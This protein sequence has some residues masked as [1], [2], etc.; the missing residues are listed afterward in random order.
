MAERETSA[1]IDEQAAEWALRVDDASFRPADKAAMDA[2]LGGDARRIGAYAKARAVLI[3]AR[4]ASALGSGFDPDAYLAANGHAGAQ[5]ADAEDRVLSRA[6]PRRAALLGGVGL[7]GFGTIAALGFSLQAAARTYS[8]RRG[9]I[10]LVPLNDGSTITLNTASMVKVR[11]NRRERHVE[12]V[13]GEALFDV[14]PDPGR[15][16]EVVVGQTRMRAIGTSFTV[17]RLSNQPIQVLVR[18]GVVEVTE[19]GRNGPVLSRLNANNRALVPTAKTVV[20]SDVAPGEMGRELAWREGMLA[21]EDTPLRSAVASFARYS[22]TR[23][24]FA[25]PAIGDRTVTGL[26]AANNPAGFAR[27]AALSLGLK[28][29][30]MENEVVLRF[31]Q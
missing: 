12:L 24:M 19:S 6:V 29:Q 25:D 21:F 8:T 2:W 13:T 7:I 9:E 16:F 28:A 5:G 14:A 18:Q 15:P 17:S 27:S 11:V 22:D 30:T 1:E 4:R 23:I 20:V 10:R 3:H 26:F 31:D